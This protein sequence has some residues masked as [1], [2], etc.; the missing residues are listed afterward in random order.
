MYVLLLL[1]VL[2][3]LLLLLLLLLI[4]LKADSIK[5][6]HESIMRELMEKFGEVTDIIMKDYK[7]HQ[8]SVV[9]QMHS[10]QATTEQYDIDD[11]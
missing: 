3:W 4:E 8:V 1:F 10:L 11:E 9:K 2:L 5:E 6:P 7:S